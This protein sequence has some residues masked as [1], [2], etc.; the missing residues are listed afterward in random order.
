MVMRPR[1]SVAVFICCVPTC[2]NHETVT[3]DSAS[4]VKNEASVRNCHVCEQVAF[5]KLKLLGHFSIF[6]TQ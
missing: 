2:G 5:L 1:T 6:E 3:H 4:F